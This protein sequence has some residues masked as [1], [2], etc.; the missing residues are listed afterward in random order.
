MKHSNFPSSV[1]MAVTTVTILAIST[2]I[3]IS[4]T[5]TSDDQEFIA[6]L[7]NAPSPVVELAPDLKAIQTADMIRGYNGSRFY[8]LRPKVK[9]LETVSSS[10]FGMNPSNADNT[11]AFLSA[12]EYLKTHPGTRFVIE[13][14]VYHFHPA[15]SA[16]TSEPVRPIELR[17]LED[18]FI[19]GVGA[20]FITGRKGYF[21]GIYDCRCLEINGLS[22]D[23]ERDV[24]PIDDVFRVRNADPEH[25]TLDLEFFQKDSVD[26][27]MEIQAITQCDPESY[28]FGA[29][30]SS[31][32]W[33]R[34]LKP[35]AIKSM[36]NVSSNTLRMTHDGAVSNFA[37][38]ETYIL[39][40]H[41]YDGTIFHLGEGS[42]D[43]TLSSVNIF[44]SPGMALIVGGGASHYQ[45][46]DCVVGVNP[47][48]A[49]LHHVSLGS[50]AVHIS[51]S[52]GCFRIKGCDMSRQ[53]DDAVNVHDGLGYVESVEGCVARMYAAS[54][55]LN[56]GDTLS[57][58]DSS[59]AETGFKALISAADLSGPV[60]TLT[61]DRDISEYVS[62]GFIAWNLGVD[63]GNYVITDNYFHENRARGILLQ[64][65]RG[66]CS[67]NRFYKI[68]GMALRI[69]M[70][71]FQNFWQEGTGVDGLIVRDNVF[72]MCDYGAWGMQIEIT[73]SIN[74]RSAGTPVFHHVEIT[75]NSFINSSSLVLSASNVEDMTFARNTI[76]GLAEESALRIGDHCTAIDFSGNTFVRKEE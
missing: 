53:G 33:Y 50:D 28:T 39:R 41:V 30:G 47:E 76:E 27:G 61:F 22:V 12:I 66:V 58:R 68:Q 72:D 16:D 32:E 62:P 51:N 11:E 29:R 65:S 6:K 18:I 15:S 38:G 46:L 9:M 14:G 37:D 69:V 20:E 8:I 70:D 57:F 64:S 49:D 7:E 5:Q 13:K 59:F 35:D 56:V 1:I 74:G 71:V 67:G 23:W 43:V 17:G 75:D 26:A 3:S 73:T 24:D 21:I 25:C 54:M 31:K 52:N 63:S 4:C 42:R 45:M 44:G 10:D 34:Y 48:L 2:L 60:K 55:Q 19:D 36:V 40:H